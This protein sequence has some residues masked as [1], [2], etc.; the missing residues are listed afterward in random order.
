MARNGWRVVLASHVSPNS[1]LAAFIL[2]PTRFWPRTDRELPFL[3]IAL[4]KKY[5][6]NGLHIQ[7]PKNWS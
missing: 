7:V 5:F 1:V 2:L 3:A 6:F 4:P